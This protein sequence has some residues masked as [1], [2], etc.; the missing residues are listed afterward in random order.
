[1]DAATG[2]C[3]YTGWLEEKRYNK[4]TGEY[5]S[6]GEFTDFTDVGEY[7]IECDVIGRSYCF[8]IQEGL[9]HA[10]NAA[11][12]PRLSYREVDAGEEAIDSMMW[13]M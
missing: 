5:N 2:Q 9:L 4:E 6:Y 11:G 7:Y 12:I 3:L 1:M 8:V 10:E 13:D